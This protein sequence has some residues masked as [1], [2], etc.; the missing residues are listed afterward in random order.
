MYLAPASSPRVKPTHRDVQD[1]GAVN[2]VVRGFVVEG[3]TTVVA[4]VG[5]A[6]GGRVDDIF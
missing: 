3:R 2:M 4:L 6:V 1:A 5:E